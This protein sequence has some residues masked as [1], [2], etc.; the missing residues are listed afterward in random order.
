MAISNK[1][2]QNRFLKA[3]VT[4]LQTELETSQ[5]DNIKKTE[6]LQINNEIRK[7]VEQQK[8]EACSKNTN[9]QIKCTKLEEKNQEIELKLKDNEIE[10][11]D[12]RRDVDSVKKELKSTTQTNIVLEKRLLKSQCDYEATKSR[13]IIL[14]KG[15]K[16]FQERLREDRNFW[17]KQI[18]ILKKQRLDLI[19]G[20]KKQMMLLNN[21]KKQNL[22][23]EQAKL[24]DFSEKEFT[25]ILEWSSRDEKK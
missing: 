24:I 17:E 11:T 7:Q 25:K 22:C 12:L 14:E 1:K 23:L 21:L 9:L 4:I 15:E 16:E 2:F 6:D 13:V 3:K 8:D 19:S 5:K 20:Y 18:K 10:L